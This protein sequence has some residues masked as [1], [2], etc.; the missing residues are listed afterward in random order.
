MGNEIN[1]DKIMKKVAEYILGES[2]KHCPVDL[3]NLRLSLGYRIEGD[4]IYITSPLDYAE[5]MEYGIPPSPEGIWGDEAQSIKEWAER[6]HL[7]PWAVIKSIEKHGIKVGT[8]EH[9]MVLKNGTFRPF[10]RS[11]VFNNLD[12]IRQV[13]QLELKKQMT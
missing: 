2:V 10:V 13:A 8:P 4:M 7:N 9:P 6:H 12:N 11:A 1:I 5:D 3:G